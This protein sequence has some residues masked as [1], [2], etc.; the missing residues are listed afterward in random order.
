M[1]KVFLVFLAS[2]L[3]F[4][5]QKEHTPPKNTY[6]NNASTI[7]LE[8]LFAKFAAEGLARGYDIDLE[9]ANIS[10]QISEINTEYVAG[11][12][13][14]GL[15]NSSQIIID[16]T[17]WYSMSDLTKEMI[18]F[19]ELGHCYLKRSHEDGTLSNGAC[20]SVMRSG[21]EDCSDN[22]TTITRGYYID[23]LFEGADL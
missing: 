15:N 2:S 4:S 22:Y 11:R 12:C 5:C 21:L 10:G 9:S 20:M 13:Y 18:V 3:F 8:D 19:H 1:K 7:T 6:Q 23:E 16:S 17:F 14:A